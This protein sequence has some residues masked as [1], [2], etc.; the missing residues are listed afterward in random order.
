MEGK[1]ITAVPGIG[2]AIGKRLKEYGIDTVEDLYD[3]FLENKEKHKK[4]VSL[5]ESKETSISQN[6]KTS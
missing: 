1:T 6:V 4:N 5:Y 3:H 2:K